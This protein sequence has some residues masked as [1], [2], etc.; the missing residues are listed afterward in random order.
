MRESPISV[1]SD[2]CPGQPGSNLGV[3][4]VGCPG[5]RWA[6]VPLRPQPLD[7][8]GQLGLL[9]AVLAELL[10]VLLGRLGGLLYELVCLAQRLTNA[11]SDL[12]GCRLDL[13]WSVGSDVLVDGDA[14]QP[15]CRRDDVE[16]RLNLPGQ[17]PAHGP[18]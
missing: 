2:H 9:L 14:G 8:V 15:G 6:Y 5:F 1:T 18:E 17:P 7:I 12:V 4:L 3:V 13:S 16:G 10:V 11:P